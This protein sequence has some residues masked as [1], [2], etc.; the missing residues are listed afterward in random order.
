M[1]KYKHKNEEIEEYIDLVPVLESLYMDKN[2]FL[3]P[4]KRV[5]IKYA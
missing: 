1:A 4:I 3:S 2:K 5:E